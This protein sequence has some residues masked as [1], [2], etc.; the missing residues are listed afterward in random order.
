MN[1][2]RRSR[3][4]YCSIRN[5]LMRISRKGVCIFLAGFLLTLVSCRTISTTYGIS[6]GTLAATYNVAKYAAKAS[7]GTASLTYRIGD[8]TFHVITAPLEWPMTRNVE[9]IDGISPKEAI[10]QGR[11]K[12]SPYVVNGRKYYPMSVSQAGQYREVG[13][14]SWYGYETLRQ[15]GGHMTA[16]GESFDPRLP[17]A[18]HKYLPLPSHV[19]VTNL[20]NGRSMVLRVNDRGPFVKNRIID[21]SAGAA[22]RLGFYRRGTTKVLV[23]TVQLN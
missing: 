18:A 23:E 1:N 11:V 7:L 22:Q 12:R 10:R 21:L 14:A 16:N 9:S 17:T 13:T 20:A 6:K 5:V 8:I 4:A 3:E 19:R 15:E 2:S